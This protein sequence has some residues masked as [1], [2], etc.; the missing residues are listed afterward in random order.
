MKKSIFTLL[1]IVFSALMLS[2]CGKDDTVDI[3]ETNKQTVIVFMPWSG[4]DTRTGLYDI[5]LQNLDSIESAVKKAK[6][7]SGKLVVYISRSASSSELY[8]VTYQNGQIVHTPIKSYTSPIYTTTEGITQILHDVQSNAYALNY[9][10]I[11]GCHGTGW[12]YKED[13]KQYPYR[14][15]LNIYD[16]NVTQGK[17]SS[18]FPES[19][20]SLPPTRFYGSVDDLSYS[21]N[22]STLADAIRQA[23][24]MMQYIL[25]DDCYMA[26]I[27]T[28][29]ELRNAT[30]FLIGST[31]EIM[32]LGMPY[33]TMWS[34]LASATPA[35]TTAVKSFY[36]FYSKYIYPYG[37]LSAI[38]CRQVE[39]LAKIMKTINSHYTLADSLV[40]SVQVLD[41]FH[42]P[43]FFDMGDYVDHLCENAGLRSDF[44]SQLAKVIK[45]TV[46][47]DTLYSS[48]GQGHTMTKV[49]TY[50][51]ITIS[52][53][54]KHS[55]AMTGKLKTAWWQATH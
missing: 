44:H 46:Y 23:G 17:S 22:I 27:E 54:S 2:S 39:G 5:F 43:I 3:T 1:F 52:D 30:N 26:N 18:A 40:D 42:T 33:Q 29:Y 16:P 31:S 21:T 55:V 15:K 28:A 19:V 53:P 20:E 7:I 32:A 41:G 50:S 25:F 10:M 11:I 12:T 37:A 36:D 4:S 6:G 47:T 51:G 14:A 24:M 45:S 48:M 34:S 49:N 13:W 35:Y 38:D 9:A 8:E